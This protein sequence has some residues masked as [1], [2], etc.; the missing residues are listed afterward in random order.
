MIIKLKITFLLVIIFFCVENIQAADVRWNDFGIF[1]VGQIL[2]NGDAR[3]DANPILRD[4]D[5]DENLT[6]NV[7][8]VV[9]LQADVKIADG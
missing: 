7:L 4:S 6:F 3:Y 1:G 2:N 5:L 9:G 8:S